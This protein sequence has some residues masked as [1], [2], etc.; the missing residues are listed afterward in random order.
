M[1]IPKLSIIIPVFNEERT[2][3]IVTERILATKFPGWEIE[4]I[5]V[6][7]G[8]A[9][10]TASVLN[11]FSSKIKVINLLKNV[12]KGSAVK[13]G[14]EAATGDFAIIQDAD[15]E[16]KPEEIPLLLEALKKFPRDAKIAV[17]GSR[18]LHGRK[19]HE[20]LFF[21]R[22][23]SLSI[24]KLINVLYGASLTD[25][26]M[27]YKLFPRA[28]FSYFQAGGFDSEMIFLTRL[29]AEGYRI[30][31]VP[32]SYTP[33]STKEGKKISYKHG[34]KIIFKIVTFWLKS[35]FVRK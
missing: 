12:G 18:E 13:A 23:G 8:S 19:D 34:I 30:V 24:T 27:C 21:H 7:D 5:A 25:T 14:I 28:T 2:V 1:N 26:L 31:E 3:G 29:L 17:M 6:N 20:S 11:S 32:V 9:D 4:V 15:L 22:L 33:R 16:C 10:N 35:H